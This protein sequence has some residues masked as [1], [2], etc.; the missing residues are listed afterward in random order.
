MSPRKTISEFTIHRR[1][2]PHWELPGETY[3]VTVTLRNRAVCDLTCDEIAPIILDPLSYY[4]NRRY[5]LFDHT[6]MPDHI[7]FIIQPIEHDGTTD[8]L[9]SIVGDMKKFTARLINKQIGRTGTLWQDESF[10]RIIRDIK[11]YREKAKYIFENPIR[12]GRVTQ[13]ED[14]KWWRACVEPNIR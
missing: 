14:W 12:A 3:F 4:A 10:D 1:H 8:S 11:E 6:I 7:H 13:G 5:F 9:G 2:L